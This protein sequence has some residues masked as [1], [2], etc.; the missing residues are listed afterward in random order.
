[1]E[2]LRGTQKLGPGWEFKDAKKSGLLAPLPPR[3]PPW[4]SLLYQMLVVPITFRFPPQMMSWRLSR[5][6]P[7]GL[8]LGQWGLSF[9]RC[10]QLPTTALTCLCSLENLPV[11]TVDCTNITFS[12][13]PPMANIEERNKQIAKHD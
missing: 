7:L 8:P 2:P 4:L 13:E 10:F 11:H 12:A 3:S 5:L 9:R 6:L 1:M